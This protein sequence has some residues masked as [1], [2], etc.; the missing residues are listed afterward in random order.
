[1]DHNGGRAGFLPIAVW[2]LP[3]TA[4]A[5]AC[6]PN[7]PGFASKQQTSL[8]SSV[9]MSLPSAS[10]GASQSS[11]LAA[12]LAAS[13]GVPLS[14]LSITSVS[15]GGGASRRLAQATSTPVT[16]AFTVLEPLAGRVHAGRN[17]GCKERRAGR[18][19]VG[20]CRV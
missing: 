3:P 1:M 10:L 4:G 14:Q 11:A 2:E 16:V 13:L 6:T 8:A 9:V 19:A 5:A 20:Q 17:Y 15:A 7:P 12:A 18:H